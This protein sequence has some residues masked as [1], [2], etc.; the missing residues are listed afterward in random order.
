MRY[1]LHALPEFVKC[2]HF[3]KVERISY[4][5]FIA[6]NEH[7]KIIAKQTIDKFFEQ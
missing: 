2:T 1:E 4:I 6:I 5:A 7:R 3:N